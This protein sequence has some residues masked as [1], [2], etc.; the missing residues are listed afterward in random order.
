MVIFEAIT[1]DEVWQKAATFLASDKSVSLRS[2][3]GGDTKEVLHACFSIGN[4]RERWVL[5]RHP[6]INPAFAIA[7]VVWIMNGRNDARFVSFFNSQLHKYVGDDESCYGAYGFRLRNHFLQDQ[8]ERAYQALNNNQHTRQVVLQIWDTNTDMP[9]TDGSARGT[10][11][12]CNIVSLLKV[13][14]GALEWMQI[15]RSNDIFRGTPYNFIQFTYLHEIMAGWLGINVGSYNQLSDSLHV[16]VR[17]ELQLM[18]FS[19]T[20]ID[21]NSDV[22]NYS[23]NVSDA[24]FE[25]LGNHIDALILPSSTCE[26]AASLLSDSGLLSPYKNMFCVLV[27]EIARRKQWSFMADTAIDQCTNPTLTRAWRNWLSR[28]PKHGGK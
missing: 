11:I 6:A 8:L 19:G 20:P 23:K 16:Y 3:R 26:E 10:D 4:P 7:E 22:F 17:D 1:A 24:N 28:F 2:G 12:P 15:M 13:D 14:N 21:Q 5:N 27:A 18:S 25:I 9:H